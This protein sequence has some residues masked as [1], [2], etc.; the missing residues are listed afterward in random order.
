[1][2]STNERTNQKKKKRIRSTNERTNQKKEA[3]FVFNFS[4]SKKN[5]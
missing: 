5:I 3:N 2:R 1:M 4:C